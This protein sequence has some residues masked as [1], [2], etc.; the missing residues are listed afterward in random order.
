MET[1]LIHP[2]LYNSHDLDG[3]LKGTHKLAT[4]C[5][6]LEKQS[7]LFP[8]RY[9]PQKYLGDGF[10]FF[11]EALIKLSPV[12]NR[13]GIGSF[14]PIL[15]GDTGVDGV[16][17]GIDGN[18]A[19]VQFKYRSDNTQVLTANEDHLS[20][21]VMSSLIRYGVNPKTN[22]N[23]LI[24]TTAEGLHYF[25]NNEMFQKQV[26]CIG[27]NQ[28]RELVDNNILFWNSFRE[29]IKNSK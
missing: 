3:L 29:L 6:R 14:S 16:G 12:D 10:E 21:F 13:I 28:L 26:R 22:T 15:E 8:N 17:I 27:Y 11:G 7:I 23:M 19:T 24:I 25:T 5:G 4:Y 2:F 9:E 20:N 18:P 1:K